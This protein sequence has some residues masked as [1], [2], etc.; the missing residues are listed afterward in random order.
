M[1]LETT[2]ACR[3]R[4]SGWIFF[5]KVQCH[6]NCLCHRTS[7]RRMKN[8]SPLFRPSLPHKS[9]TAIDQAA[10]FHTALKA[11]FSF[12]LYQK[13]GDHILTFSVTLYQRKAWWPHSCSFFRTCGN[14]S[15][16]SGGRCS[17][18]SPPAHSPRQS[19]E[20]ILVLF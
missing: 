5:L 7:E 10:F 4:R 16:C 18:P 19:C 6:P 12:T 9:L 1:T 17:E 15:R 8:T 3:N 11:V 2:V 20:G 13:L 14:C